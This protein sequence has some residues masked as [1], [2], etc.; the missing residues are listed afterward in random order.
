M[1]YVNASASSKIEI[2]KKNGFRSV[3]LIDQLLFQL[4][5]QAMEKIQGSV[6]NSH[7]L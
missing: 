5:I 6:Y 2:N 1:I 4:H 7:K 3:T